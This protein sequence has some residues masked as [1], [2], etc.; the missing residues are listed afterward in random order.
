MQNSRPTGDE[1]AFSQSSTFAR[2]F[3]LRGEVKGPFDLDMIEAFVLSGYYPRGVQICAEGSKE[4]HSYLPPNFDQRGPG[5]ARVVN[6]RIDIGSFE[7][8]VGGTPTPTATA[9]ATDTVSPTPTATARPSPTP[10]SAP[11]PRPR[12]TPRPRR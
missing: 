10:R 4:W 11:T 7:V 12:S 1:Y 9:T 3:R 8:Q 2:R 5:F 6:G